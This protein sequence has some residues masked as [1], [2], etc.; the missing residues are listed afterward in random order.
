MSTDETIA[1]NAARAHVPYAWPGLVLAWLGLMIG[2]ATAVF[3]L[4]HFLYSRPLDLT[5][6]SLERGQLIEELLLANRVPPE[7]I[8]RKGPMLRKG[9]AAHL[10]YVEYEAR[11]PVSVSAYGLDQ[12][13]RRTME[14]EHVVVTDLYQDG[15]KRGLRLAVGDHTFALVTLH[16]SLPESAGKNAPVP[17]PGP[18]PAA[19]VE[20]TADTPPPVEP[21]ADTPTAPVTTASPSDR[22]APVVGL[23]T[24]EPARLAIIVDD[25]GYGGDA[26]EIILGLDPRL[27]LAI[28]PNTPHAAETVRRARERGF[29]VIL[30]MPMENLDASLYPHDGQLL[31]SMN[32]ADIRRRVEDALAQVPG[33]VGVNNHM[34]SLFTQNPKAMALFMEVIRE[35]DLFF[36]DS[37]TTPHT[38]AHDI[39]RAFGV[40]SAARDL[41][42]DHEPGPDEIRR[43]LNQVVTLARERGHAI[44]ICHFRP[45]T[46]QALSELLPAL[47]ESG[48][49]LVPAS[50]LVR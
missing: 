36:I 4:V 12:V 11:V 50:E 45:T 48:V 34:G 25:G 29:E 31:V 18:A 3:L 38:R 47:A 46:A 41:F 43:R 7:N 42:L 39:A 13:I 5:G 6:P 17:A 14:R 1:A 33:A 24:H 10:Y 19:G 21:T 49:E 32:E 28:L 40:P 26:T 15:A 27:T 44:A 37:R 23:T 16:A 30:H 9:Q 35:H 22:T 2:A 20:R 8:L